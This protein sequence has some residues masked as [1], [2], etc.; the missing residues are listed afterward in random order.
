[1]E[2]TNTA[3]FHLFSLLLQWLQIAACVFL[4]NACVNNHEHSP[5]EHG[6]KHAEKEDLVK[7]PEIDS[8]YLDMTAI[9]QTV[10]FHKPLEKPIWQSGKGASHMKDEDTVIGIEVE[11]QAYALP[12]WILK[13]HHVA[14]LTLGE[15]AVVVT[16]CEMCGSGSAFKAVVGG[17]KMNFREHGIYKGTWFMRDQETDSFWLPFEGKAFYGA[18]KDSALTHI[19][20]YQIAWKD[21]G[22]ENPNTMV[23]YDSQSKREGHGAREYLGYDRIAPIYRG[24]LPDSIGTDL[25]MFDIVLGVGSEGVYKAYSMKDLDAEGK[26]LQDTLSDGSTVVVFHKPNTTMAGAFVPII[27]GQSVSFMVDNQGDIRD[28]QTNSRWNY[29]GEC[30]EGK[31]QGTQL[32][33]HFFIVKEWYGWYGYHPSTDVFER[34]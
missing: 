18:L 6:H 1:M 14:N 9:N 5:N 27:E 12:W 17:K 26:V 34:R 16:L 11:D 28:E 31:L 4:L 21:W 2:K 7:H 13:N 32:S 3:S 25:P 20:T 30:V 15:Q 29:F 8:L 22:E 24:T 23:L 33:S 19:D 10:D